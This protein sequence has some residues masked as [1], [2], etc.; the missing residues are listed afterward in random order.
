MKYT[1]LITSILL[2]HSCDHTSS[3]DCDTFNYDISEWSTTDD[4][5]SSTMTFLDDQSNE[6]EFQLIETQLSEP[7]AGFQVGAESPDDVPCFSIKANF[8]RNEQLD[9][10][11]SFNYERYEL[12]SSDRDELS[13]YLGI[14]NSQ[15]DTLIRT[16]AL[17]I[18]HAAF[19]EQVETVE[20][21]ELSGQIYNDVIK[22]QINQMFN[23][24]TQQ[25]HNDTIIES[26]FFKQPI[27]LVQIEFSDGTKL[28][29][30][31]Q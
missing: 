26:L 31:K 17:Y 25:V 20:E 30:K 14:I 24:S 21:I 23:S 9:T 10:E 4:N 16:N 6:F 11:L 19:N 8:Y 2:F 28:I 3:R 1:L 13:F 22:F 27:G 15:N 29:K 7:Y 12:P 18:N 5:N